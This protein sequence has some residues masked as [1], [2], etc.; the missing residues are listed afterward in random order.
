MLHYYSV[1]DGSLG[2]QRSITHALSSLFAKFQEYNELREKLTHP[3]ISTIDQ[4]IDRHHHQQQQEQQGK[5]MNE[6]HSFIVVRQDI[7]SFIRAFALQQLTGN[8]TKTAAATNDDDDVLT[9]QVSYCATD[10]TGVGGEGPLAISGKLKKRVQIHP[11]VLLAR[12][13]SKVRRASRISDHIHT[14]MI[15]SEQKY[16]SSP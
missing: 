16:P 15:H 6:R 2:K 3:G 13:H 4:S 9:L 8:N 14:Y 5:Y 11:S 1:N 10:S 7:H 12:P